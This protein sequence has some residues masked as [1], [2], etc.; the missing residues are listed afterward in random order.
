MW[1]IQR[2]RF[3]D[4]DARQRAS[5][6][7]LASDEFDRFPI[8][9][10]TTWATPQWSFLGVLDG[11]LACFYNLV[12][13][14]VRFD[15]RTLKVA[16]LNNLVTRPACRGQGLAARLLQETT[17]A[18]FGALGATCGLLLCADALVPYYRRLGWRQAAS[19]VRCAQPDGDRTW[20]ANC[21]LLDPAG[22]AGEPD[23]IDLCGLPW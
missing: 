19:T 9:R 21:M 6:R 5:L 20:Q 4:L 16:G 2:H 11:E 18:W 12:W 7:Q 13:R 22:T 1:T 3:D 23:L 10:E 17:P 15:G 8:V 14:E